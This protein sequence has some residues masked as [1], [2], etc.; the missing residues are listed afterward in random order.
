MDRSPT[1]KVILVGVRISS[2][3]T[4]NSD[5][6][7]SDEQEDTTMNRRVSP[8]VMFPV[9]LLLAGCPSG[10]GGDGGFGV[11]G[12][13]VAYVVNTGPN[14]ISAYTTDV[15]GALRDAGTVA[16]ANVPSSIS[17]SSDSAFAFAGTNDG[18]YA[19]RVNSGTGGLSSVSGSPFSTGNSF[20]ALTV[21]PNNRVLYAANGNGTVVA[22]SINA[23]TG[24]LTS[25]DTENVGTS[26]SGVVVSPN[27][28]F[29]YVSN[30]GS[31]NVSA[32]TINGTTGALTGVGAPVAAG[33]A[34]SGVA[35]SLSS[36]FL[37]VSNQGS[38]NVSAFTI[39]G[40]TGALTGIGAPVAAGTA[41]SGVAV[42]PNGSFLYVSNQGSND[43][44]AFTINGTTGAL[45]P[46]GVSTFAAGTSP[47]GITI[48][49]NGQFLYV[50]N[51][52]GGG[53]VS[54]YRITAGTGSLV[55]LGAAYP[56]GTSPGAIATPGRP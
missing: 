49:P 12:T 42:S 52:G 5:L 16:L 19:F 48:E 50:S 25:I 4:R 26:P 24:S 20:T 28:Q 55:S 34:P 33:T 23:T 18:V 15:V 11:G 54:G 3:Y 40:T 14:E 44:S 37:Y 1:K 31:D 7:F 53:N 2:C 41:P 47:S 45:A 56:A 8:W 36:Q 43:V 46:I 29:L 30:Q 39:N 38:D 51:S 22:Y 35:V 9:L 17:V 32:F 6:M 13:G 27:G 21:S 10:G